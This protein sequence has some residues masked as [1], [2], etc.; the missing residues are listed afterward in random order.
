VT[1]LFFDVTALIFI[2]GA[3]LNAS[4]WRWRTRRSTSE[5]S[6]RASCKNKISESEA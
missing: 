4:L 1:L 5:L 6:D 3:E 2:F